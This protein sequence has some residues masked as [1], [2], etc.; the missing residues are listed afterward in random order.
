[1]A[2]MALAMS[3]CLGSCGGG[4]GGGG[5]QPR[6]VSSD[7]AAAPS[8]PDGPSAAKSLESR[9]IVG[10]QGW[11]G[12][13]ADGPGAPRWRHWF[14]G[15]AGE[16]S[17]LTVDMLP[18]VTGLPASALCETPLRRADASPVMVYSSQSAEVIDRHFAW[19][20]EHGIDGAAVQRFVGP[21]GDPI[22]RE[23]S[24]R[25]LAGVRDAAQRHGRVFY[26]TYDVSGASA[27]SVYD[28]LRSD[29]RHLST[30]LRITD[31]PA[32]LRHEDAPL[33]Q[34]WGFGFTDRPGD[35]ERVLALMKDLRGAAGDRAGAVLIGGVPSQWRTLSGD[36]KA[37]ATW[38][39]V[40]RAYDVLSPWAVGRY[41][42]RASDQHFVRNV[43]EGDLAETR[44]LGIGYLP[45]VFPGFSWANLMTVRGHLDQ[46]LPNRIPRRCGD[47]L[48]EQGRSRIAAGSRSLFVAMFDEVDE[49]T[50]IM[51][52]ETRTARLPA[53][54]G[55]IAL[56]A[57][58]CELP[59]DWYL[60]VT[61]QLAAHVRR[62]AQLPDSLS[63]VLSR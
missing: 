24:D 61:G 51:P 42:D 21:L 45:V 44:R 53:S 32:Y 18:D 26:V 41:A 5:G 2:A 28:D 60:R 63:A 33:L 1:M 57:D 35:P 46:A 55:L 19:M 34:L 25:I 13:P 59:S 36:A 62:G 30:T 29:W 22:E 6:L 23:R 40:Y 20:A 58:G 39:G 37:D 52:V 31:S 4:G 48:W 49:G 17:T 3:V 50:A 16:P 56:D 47:F 14:D 54:T 15:P 38:S 7:G 9:L 12:C 43:V 8:A 10:Y 11:F 27:A